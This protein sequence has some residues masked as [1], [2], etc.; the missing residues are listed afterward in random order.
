[1]ASRTFGAEF[2]SAVE[3]FGFNLTGFFGMG[4]ADV[5][6]GLTALEYVFETF[7]VIVELK[8]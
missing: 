7:F 3:L 1:V 4:T 8:Y 5:T 6:L 2:F